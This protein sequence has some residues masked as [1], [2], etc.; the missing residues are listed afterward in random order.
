M[1]RA[2]LKSMKRPKGGAVS[3]EKVEQPSPVANSGK[4]DEH[5]MTLRMPKTMAKAL[6]MRAIDEDSNMTEII[7]RAVERELGQRF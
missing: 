2:S 5:A 4:K 6:K 7:L 3:Q 1:A